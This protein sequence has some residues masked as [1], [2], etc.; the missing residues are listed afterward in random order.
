M[1]KTLLCLCSLTGFSFSSLNAEEL[2]LIPLPNKVEQQ[3]NKHFILNRAVTISTPKEFEET[4][5]AGLSS[6]Q[7]NF[8]QENPAIVISKDETIKNKEAY[9]LSVT[10]TGIQIKAKTLSGVFYATQTLKQLLPAKIWNKKDK[11]ASFTVPCVKIEDAPRFGWRGL[12]LDSSRHFQ[13]VEE[14]QRFI[15]N[16]AAH[17]MNVFHWHLT[18]GHGWHFESKK[19]PNLHKRGSWR[20]QPGYPMKGKKEKYGGYYTQKEMKEMVEYARVRGVTI[21]PEIDM[22][23]HC[24]AWV[25][26]YPNTGCLEKEQGLD[27]FYEYPTKAQRFPSK[28]GTDVLCVGKDEVIKMSKDIIDEM[29]EIFPSEFI[30]IGGDEV[31]KHWWKACKHCNARKKDKGLK[32]EYELQSWY[33]QQLDNHI[34]SK[35]RRLVGWDEILEGGLAKNA[36]VMSW[37]GEKG[38]IKA[39]KMGHDVVMSPQTTIYLDHGQSH[40]ELEPPHWP[41]HKPLDT[42]YKYEP[43]PPSFTPD[44]AKRILG[45]Q[46]NVW[47]VFTHEEWL[48]DICTWPRAA[49]V[50]E[51]GWSKK[52]DKNWQNF[53]NRLSTTHRNRLDAMGINYWWENNIEYGTW[54]P[55]D[56]KKKEER[57]TLSFDVTGKVKAGKNSMDFIYSHGYLGLGIEEVFLLEDGKQVANKKQ[58]GFTGHHSKNNRYT[59][60]LPALNKEAKYTLKARVHASGKGTDSHGRI[61]FSEVETKV[62]KVLPHENGYKLGGDNLKKR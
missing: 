47:T 38:G 27:F 53:K 31:Q 34:T 36:T 58:K 43:I 40:S 19:Y 37:T 9:T 23:G 15:D 8:S 57:V 39:A 30:H 44:Q 60:H 24:F 22:L 32:D 2:A 29:M 4:L 17:K 54:S 42:A 13:T 7:I 61:V 11:T 59:L 10:E 21:V 51:T 48:V 62:L 26:A 46:A 50:A 6:F 1:I 18:D 25:A 52:S 14:I 49:A 20:M 33:I 41:G 3:A 5:K 56:L 28:P 45:I 55:K 35:G 12:M 16:L